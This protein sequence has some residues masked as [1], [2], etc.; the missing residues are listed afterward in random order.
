MRQLPDQ[1]ALCHVVRNVSY[2][3]LCLRVSEPN[4][5][6]SIDAAV[7]A[8]RGLPEDL[9]R[10][11][12]GI[13]DPVDLIDDLEHALLEAGAITVSAGADQYQF[14]RAT[15]PSGGATISRAVEKL[16]YNE[17]PARKKEDR[18]WFVSAPGKVILFGEHAVVH[19]VVSCSH[20]AFTPE[21]LMVLQTAIAASVGLRCYG[22]SSPRHDG[23]IALR[24]IDLDNFSHEWVLD[25]LPW[26]AVTSVGVGD[27]HPDAL[28][29]PLVDAIQQRG[30]P[31][32][33]DQNAQ[34]KAAAVA[35]LYLYMVMTHGGERLASLQSTN[36]QLWLTLAKA[37][38]RFNRKIGVTSGRRSR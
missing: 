26:D 24:L 11:C 9:I 31:S 13:E 20:F 28:D 17:P 7:R 10:L 36:K 3:L 15:V 12:V 30:L 32:N 38:I 29:Q 8:E 5:H 35:F 19:G 27:P 18:E 1:H 33:I 37:I 6:A 4:S 25:D 2:L 34:A 23:K 14:V 16:A 21:I 22:L